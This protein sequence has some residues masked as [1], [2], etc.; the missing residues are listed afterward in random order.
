LHDDGTARGS[1]PQPQQA[2][3]PG[4]AKEYIQGDAK[5]DNFPVKSNLPLHVAYCERHMM[6]LAEGHRLSCVFRL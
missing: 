4:A 2:L 6:N 3:Q 5:S 1:G